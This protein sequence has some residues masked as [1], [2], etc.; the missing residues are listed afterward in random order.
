MFKSGVSNCE[1]AE[2]SMVVIRADGT[3]QDLGV[4]SYYNKNPFKRTM[5]YIKQYFNKLKTFF[6]KG[7]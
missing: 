2:V 1:S 6:I 4:V 7:N 3:K 5:F